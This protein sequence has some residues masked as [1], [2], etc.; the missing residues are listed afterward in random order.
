MIRDSK[1]TEVFSGDRYTNFWVNDK[2][3]DYA[4]CLSNEQCMMAIEVFNRYEDQLSTEVVE[5]LEPILLVVLRAVV[6]GC[7]QVMVYFDPRGRH[8]EDVQ[9]VKVLKELES[10]RKPIYLREWKVGHEE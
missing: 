10:K 9:L 3:K 1:L 4:S 5:A 6:V 7:Y 2:V 8:F